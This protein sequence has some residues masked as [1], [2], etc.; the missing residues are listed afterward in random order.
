LSRNR[1]ATRIPTSHKRNVNQDL[2]LFRIVICFSLSTYQIN[3]YFG[4]VILKAIDKHPVEY[5]ENEENNRE[6][7]PGLPVYPNCN[8]LRRHRCPHELLLRFI[9][10]NRD[11]AVPIAQRG[12]TRV[13]P[14][15]R[16]DQSHVA[17]RPQLSLT[18]SV[19][20]DPLRVLVDACFFRSLLATLGITAPFRMYFGLSF[21]SSTIFLQTRFSAA[22]VSTE[23]R[24]SLSP[25]DDVD[26]SELG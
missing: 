26:E 13:L 8:F 22:V 5:V 7:D 3:T 6:Y 19:C 9:V 17:A 18:L 20:S 12:L 11:H 23:R 2:S 10:G 21:I 1:Y 25:P 24:Y 4:G 15:K 14:L 16:A